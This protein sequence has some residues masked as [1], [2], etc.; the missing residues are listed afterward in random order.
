MFASLRALLSGIIDYAGLFPP[1][2]LPLEEAVRNYARYRAGPCSWML[3]RFVCSVERLSAIR[4]LEQSLS[5]GGARDEAVIGRG[6]DDSFLFTCKLIQDLEF[7][8]SEL[9][10]GALET[11]L[12]GDII[13]PDRKQAARRL[14]AHVSTYFFASGPSLTPY[15][16]ASLPANWREPL[17]TLLE[18]MS[19]INRADPE[20][21]R[22]GFKLRTG[23]LEAFSF[24]TPEQVAFTIV[25]CRDAG[26]PLKFTAGLHHPIRHFDRELN[27]RMHGFLNVFGAGVLAHARGLSEDQVRQIIE[28]EDPAHFV[29]D[30]DVLCWKEWR[31]TTAEI[32]AA[33]KEGVT[34]FGSCSFDE[35]WADLRALGLL[36]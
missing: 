16:E 19:E 34:S 24:P 8:M 1:A 26:V 7:L 29:F 21:F 32:E 36:E 13:G 18:V 6:G 23:G 25:T 14:M 27:T 28:D 20:N 30:D 17:T 10:G 31:A 12:P 15:F 9:V 22:G 11:R 4:E 35:P 2:T 33:R 5:L 3:G